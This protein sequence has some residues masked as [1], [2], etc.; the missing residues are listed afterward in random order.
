VM[1]KYVRMGPVQALGL[2]ASAPR[3]AAAPAE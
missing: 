3:P 1:L 2:R